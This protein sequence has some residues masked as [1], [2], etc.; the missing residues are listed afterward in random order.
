VVISAQTISKMSTLQLG[1]YFDFFGIFKT[2]FGLNQ[3][4]S[5]G[6]NYALSGIYLIIF[7]TLWQFTV[8]YIVPK[9]D[10]M[11]IEFVHALLHEGMLFE[12][13]VTLSMV[14]KGMTLSVMVAFFISYT[15]EI[16][17]F[18]KP[19][20]KVFSKFRFW[21]F[22]GFQGVLRVL[23]V[24]GGTYRMSL[25]MFAIVPFLVTGFNTVLRGV[26][27]DPLYAYARTLGIPE[28]QVIYYV[29]FRARIASLMLS[30]KNNFAIAWVI[31]PAV[32]IANR[33][34]GGI[35]AMIF[36]KARFVPGDNGY[37]G[38]FALQVVVL[39]TGIFLDYVQEKMVNA[40]PEE[41]VK[42][43]KG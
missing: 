27:K 21:T 24:D 41:R 15:G 40:L 11:W 10:K 25:F 26:R 19:V 2:L 4:M 12:L 6:F 43:Q 33:D 8:P 36:D 23:A 16:F 18:M 34:A 29:V 22:F 39:F 17:N 28:W 3:P 38:A 31:A 7:L 32:E 1:K 20:A 5:R 13:G 14:F 9:L 35:G 42:N 30:I 37:A